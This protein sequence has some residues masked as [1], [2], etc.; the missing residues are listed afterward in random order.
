MTEK[1][2]L[3]KIMEEQEI[4]NAKL[5]D[6]LGITQAAAWDRLN[7]KGKKLTIRL[8]SEML[9]VMDYKIV[10]TP[11]DTKLRQGEYVVE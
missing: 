4:T 8:L 5:A 1:E 3:K 11:R 6:R 10:I 7:G 2:I 9:A